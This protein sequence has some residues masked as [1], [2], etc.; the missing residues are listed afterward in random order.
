[1]ADTQTVELNP[2]FADGDPMRVIGLCERYDAVTM[3]RIPEQWAHFQQRL[4]DVR[5]RI[6]PA[7]F[8]I[9]YQL[10]ESPFAF[11]YLT[12]VM[13]DDDAPLPAGF[14][15]R[16]LAP[17]RHAVFTHRGHP[18]GLRPLMD[19]IFREWLPRSGYRAA[20]NPD[21]VEVYGEAFDPVRLQGVIEVWVPLE[22]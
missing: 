9:F 10:S 6:D 22:S 20:G 4:S 17:R 16:R 8:G 1:M 5:G 2:R 11:E 12:A 14:V 19:A 3:N 7:Q 18:S 21:F 13:V 15:E